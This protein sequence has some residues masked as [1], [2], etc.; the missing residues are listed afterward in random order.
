MKV[1]YGDYRDK[2]I[3]HCCFQHFCMLKVKE[4]KQ[5]FI[6]EENMTLEKPKL[7]LKVNMVLFQMIVML[8]WI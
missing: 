8:S 3:D 7:T 2:L 5:I 6:D 4:T 1:T